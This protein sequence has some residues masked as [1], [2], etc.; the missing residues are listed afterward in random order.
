MSLLHRNDS[1]SAVTCMFISAGICLLNDCLAMNY[2]GFQVSCHNT[3][4]NRG[5]G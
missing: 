2:S 3:N 1:S 5:L 4:I